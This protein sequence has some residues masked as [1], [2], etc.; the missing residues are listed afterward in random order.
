MTDEV[1]A[2]I[3]GY[4]NYMVSNHGR[5]LNIK[6]GRLMSCWGDLYLQ[7]TLSVNGKRSTPT[8]HSLVANAF[9]PNPCEYKDINH[10][11]EVKKNNH[12]LN[13]EWV[14]ASMNQQHSAHH[15]AKH[16]ELCSKD[17]HKVD[18]F[19]LTQFCRENNLH[20][21]TM[22]EVTRGIRNSHK[23]WTVWK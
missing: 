18:V 15:R 6:R 20:K 22:S 8:V 2:F 4:P 9:V 23:G 13:L 5:V 10:I 19:N 16:Y 7:V 12:Y 21:G 1:W 11:D 3:E 14:T 17:G